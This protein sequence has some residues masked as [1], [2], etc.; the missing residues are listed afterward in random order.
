MSLGQVIIIIN[1]CFQKNVYVLLKEEKV[2]K[3]IIDDIE[4]PSDSASENSDKENSDKKIYWR[5]K[6]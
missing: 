5:I 2:L 6:F 4:I 3:Y 1:K